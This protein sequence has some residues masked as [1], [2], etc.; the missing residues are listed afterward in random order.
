MRHQFFI[1]VICYL[2]PKQSALYE[3][4]FTTLVVDVLLCALNCGDTKDKVMSTLFSAIATLCFW[5]RYPIIILRAY[6][7]PSSVKNR[8]SFT[9]VFSMKKMSWKFLYSFW[10]SDNEGAL[11]WRS[12]LKLNTAQVFFIYFF[13]WNIYFYRAPPMLL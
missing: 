7:R 4:I 5:L 9:E 11:A 3:I 12:L 2:R 6:A 1:L 13:S 10:K 8:S